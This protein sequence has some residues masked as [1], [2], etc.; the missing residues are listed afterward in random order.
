MGEVV[1]LGSIHD[2][3]TQDQGIQDIIIYKNIKKEYTKLI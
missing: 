1:I 2:P 3:K